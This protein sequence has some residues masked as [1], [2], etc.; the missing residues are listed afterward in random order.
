MRILVAIANYG[1]KN[2]AY[3][4]RL[5][6][7]YRAM[8]YEVHIVVLSNVPKDLG[9]DIEVV[10]GLPAKDPWSLPFAHKAVFAERAE[11]YDLFIYSEDDTLVTQRNIDAFLKV[12]ELLPEDEI[13]GFLRY[14]Q[15]GEGRKYCCTIHAHFHWRPNS[16]RRVKG[17]TFAELTNAHSACYILTRAQLL[18]AINSG[19]YLVG[20]HQ[21]H[22]D[23]LCTAATDPYT[24]CGLTK[25]VCISHIEDF[26]LHHLPNLY[27]E[28]RG[29]LVSEM[30]TQID[31]LLAVGDG[32]EMQKELFVPVTGLGV[33][34]WDK[35]YY[36]ECRD[37]VL[38][39]VPKHSQNVLSVGCGWGATEAKLVE[40]GVRVVGVPLDPVIAVSARSRGVDV[41]VPDLAR[42]RESLDGE[43]FDCILFVDVLGRLR[44]PQKILGEYATLLDERGCAV[45]TAHNFRYLGNLPK[46]LAKRRLCRGFDGARIHFTASG[47]LAR[48]IRQSG[49]NVYDVGYRLGRRA[50]WISRTSLGLM[51]RYV[52]RELVL[53]AG[54]DHRRVR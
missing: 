10:V 48:W 30:K 38:A 16:A 36:E 39:L 18:K 2:S 20:P 21:E 42:A 34:A 29:V 43:K 33:F 37:D 15:D 13:A 54:K 24:Q 25:V 32:Q 45:I 46:M 3:L 9:P 47:M 40:N 1:S 23:L 6:D 41:L 31:A 27:V 5:I 52:A 12:T 14:E 7:E 19:G 11:D 44:D 17:Y 22:Y 35:L 4:S 51:N 26:L 49:L 50:K 8:S 28:Q 53:V